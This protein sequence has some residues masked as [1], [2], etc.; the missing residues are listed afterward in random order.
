MFEGKPP[1]NPH[2]CTPDKDSDQSA[3]LRELTWADLRARLEAASELRASMERGD[4]H[5]G[6]SFDAGFASCI[7]SRENGKDA[8]NPDDLANGK[9]NWPNDGATHSADKPA[10]RGNT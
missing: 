2:G 3:N 7:A 10:S 4:S 8:V 9:G 5:P 1:L 6:A